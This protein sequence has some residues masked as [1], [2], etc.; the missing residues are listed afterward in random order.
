[1]QL[2]DGHAVVLGIV[3]GAASSACGRPRTARRAEIGA[4]AGYYAD[5]DHVF[6]WNPSVRAQVPIGERVTAS[7]SAGLDAISA[8]SVD[9]V[10]SASRVV[11]TRREFTGAIAVEPW[12]R[13]TVQAGFRDSRESDYVSDGVSLSLDRETNARDRAVHVE[14][15]GRYDQVGPGWL[16]Q[17]PVPLVNGGVA[18]SVT[19]VV[20]RW[21]VVRVAVQ[22]D[23]ASGWQASVYRYVPVAGAQYHER[24]P[25]L[26]VRGAALVRVQ[27]SVLPNLAVYG[28]YNLGGDTWDV[29]TNGVDA[30]T[31]WQLA[32]WLV[33]D[34]RLRYVASTAASFYRMRYA[35]PTT[36][37]T[38]DRVLGGVE[39]LWPRLAIEGR[40]PAWPEPTRWELGIA[41][42]VMVQ[43]FDAFELLSRR[44]ALMLE[45][46]G[47]AYF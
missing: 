42:G 23:V 47:T 41:G 12:A 6:V 13:T 24:V 26:R 9:V 38:R 22:G 20:D 2:R 5:N 7:A 29:W 3:L 15:R 28:E 46:W 17:A 32:P 8:A 19:Q 27:R 21:T 36:L 16:F 1:M 43:H 30:G 25:D 45:A 11:E 34:A 14:L 4:H 37:R 39:T 35:E 31:R 44:D 10:A 18:A 40:W 33:A